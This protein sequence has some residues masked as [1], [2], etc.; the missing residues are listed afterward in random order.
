M[1][2]EVAR[3]L[4]HALAQADRRGARR[5]RI[6][7]VRDEDAL[8]LSAATLEYLRTR[9]STP[10]PREGWV[11]VASFTAGVNRWWNLALDEPFPSDISKRLQ[12]LRGD[13]YDHLEEEQHLI[14][15][16]PGQ[17]SPVHLSPTGVVVDADALD[18]RSAQITVSEGGAGFGDAAHNAQVEAAA[19]QSVVEH[20]TGWL[21]EDVSNKKCGW[22]ITLR[23]AEEEI[24]AEVKGVSARGPRSC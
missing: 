4:R 19:M 22:D 13:I 5:P 12:T 16:A 1:D 8:V 2:S 23:R 6:T 20:F 7:D 11:Q 15:K 21:A 14:L 10:S 9:P 17:T 18:R 3:I 24:H